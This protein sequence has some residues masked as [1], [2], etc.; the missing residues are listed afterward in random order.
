[1]SILLLGTS[2]DVHQ[3]AKQRWKNSCLLL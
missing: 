2:D 1:M 3:E